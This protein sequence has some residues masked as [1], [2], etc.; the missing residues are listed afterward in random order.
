MKWRGVIRVLLLLVIAEAA[1]AEP[2]SYSVTD[3]FGRTLFFQNIPERIVIASRGTFL[4][5]DAVYLF[6]EA[7]SRVV[8][9]GSTNQGLGDPFPLL[10]PDFR[11]T[12]R[13]TN[14]VGPEQI[15]GLRP[16]LVILK[17]YNREKL[18]SILEKLGIPVLYLDLESPE[19]FYT[20]IVCIGDLFRQ[21]ERARFIVGW[22]R[23]K[24]GAVSDA[25]A[26]IRKPTVLVAQQSERDGGNSFSV[27]PA[28][29]IQTNM[30]EAA[31]GIAVWKDSGPGEGWR[32]V[33]IEQ[34]AAWDPDFILI[35]S[36][37]EPSG[38]WAERLEASGLLRGKVLPFPADFLSWDQSDSRWI[39]GLLWIASAIHPEMRPSLDISSE[40]FSFYSTLYGV[41][42]TTFDREILP[43]LAGVRARQ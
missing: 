22:Y 39:L 21:P 37:Q 10:D 29:W 15:A 13:L 31:G 26:G 41:D 5:V 42:K 7:R 33:G 1:G 3:A 19:K 24:V 14:A 20:D 8:A 27:P 16:D 28:G 4:L 30:V 23:S 36:Y 6:P 11:K 25:V 9:V 43:R 40:A 34:V 2:G 32:K 18:G 12:T 17:S 35:V 38:P